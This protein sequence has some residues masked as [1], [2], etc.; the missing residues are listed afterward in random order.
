MFSGYKDKD[1]LSSMMTNYLLLNTG[2][3]SLENVDY[4]MKYKIGFS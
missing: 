2:N 3:S 1:S 4:S